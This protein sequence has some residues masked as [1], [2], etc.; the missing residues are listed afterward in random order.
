[1]CLTSFD[2]LL[3]SLAHDASIIFNLLDHHHL[4]PQTYLD[5]A[6]PGVVDEFWECLTLSFFM[7][8]KFILPI[9][10]WPCFVRHI[11]SLL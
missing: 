2:N 10:N 8:N 4:S 7:S 6:S 3:S 11:C 9:V 1:M 5:V